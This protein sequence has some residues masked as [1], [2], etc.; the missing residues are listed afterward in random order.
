MLKRFRRKKKKK[1]EEPSEFQREDDDDSS[2]LNE[3]EEGLYD[4][5]AM[6]MGDDAVRNC[7]RVYV[8]D[9]TFDS[10]FVCCVDE[11]VIV[12]DI[13]LYVNIYLFMLYIY[14]YFFH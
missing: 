10:V 4:E 6:A 3:E 7:R 8:Y 12:G 14:I 9:S 5:P 13:Y 1:E 2:D 11:I